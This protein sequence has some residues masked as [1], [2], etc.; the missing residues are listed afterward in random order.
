ML[1]LARQDL[2]GLAP[3]LNQFPQPALPSRPF[4]GGTSLR[5]FWH[6]IWW[7]IMLLESVGTLFIGSTPARVKAYWPGAVASAALGGVAELVARPAPFWQ[8]AHFLVASGPFDAALIGIYAIQGLFY[9]QLMPPWGLGQ[10]AWALFSAFGTVA[11]EVGF[12]LLGYAGGGF[13]A[14]AA[15]GTVHLLRFLALS[16]VYHGLRLDLRAEALAARRTATR[17]AARWGVVWRLS[18]PL[19]GA[20]AWA[21]A[22]LAA[23]AA[24]RSL[25]TR[26]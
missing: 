21:V 9:F 5:T 13:S 24:S 7:P 14:F 3:T 16:G 2:P 4:D 15:S 25:P 6:G 1:F 22:R 17:R 19:W 10:L 18:W 11:M 8:P 20:I 26:D 23:R 12:A